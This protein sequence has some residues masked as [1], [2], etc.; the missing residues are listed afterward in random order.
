M[1]SFTK[2]I[3]TLSLSLG[4][5]SCFKPSTKSS[6]DSEALASFNIRQS[7][8][9]SEH[10][11]VDKNW[12]IPLSKKYNFTVCLQ[13]KKTQE[14]IIGHEFKVDIL[15][16]NSV[17]TSNAQN[18]NAQISSSDFGKTIKTDARGCLVWNESIKY[19]Y[20]ALETFI[21]QQRKITAAGL[22]KGSREFKFAINPWNK[23]DEFVDL[24]LDPNKIADRDLVKTDNAELSLKGQSK[25][26]PITVWADDLKF[27]MMD[28][29]TSSQRREIRVYG[30]FTPKI[31]IPKSDQTIS[32]KNIEDGI[33]KLK[34]FF[35][36]EVPSTKNKYI[37]FEIET[38]DLK[39][40]GGKVRFDSK[41]LLSKMQPSQ[42]ELKIAMI[43][44][45]VDPPQALNEF[46]GVYT[47][48]S[49]LD[50]N[51]RQDPQPVAE[52]NSNSYPSFKV[53]H[54]LQQQTYTFTAE[55]KIQAYKL[56]TIASNTESTKESSKDNS[57]DD[58]TN[59]LIL[60]GLTSASSY[61]L[62]HDNFTVK[63]GKIFTEFNKQYFSR[64]ITF[65]ACFLNATGSPLIG[66][67]FKVITF[68]NQTLTRTTDSSN[69]GCVKWNEEFDHLSYYAYEEPLVGKV[70]FINQM[71]EQ[72]DIPVALDPW[73]SGDG[74]DIHYDLRS[75]SQVSR[76]NKAK[77]NI[78][79]IPIKR[80][81]SSFHLVNSNK[82]TY[83]IDPYLNL[84]TTQIFK[85]SIDGASIIRND[86]PNGLVNESIQDGYY[87][88]R[89][90]LQKDYYDSDGSKK[91][92]VTTA[93][94]IIEFKNH[95]VVPGTEVQL[96]F[97]DWRF[98][99]VV[100][101][102]VLE[103][104][105]IN[106][107]KL[108]AVSGEDLASQVQNL[109]IRFAHERS[110]TPE[111]I[112]LFD[113][114]IDKASPFYSDEN[115]V[116][117]LV[118]LMPSDNDP[119]L[120][121]NNAARMMQNCEIGECQIGFTSGVSYRDPSIDP[122]VA[123]Y[124]VGDSHLINTTV[125]ML[126]I[127]EREL[128]VNFQKKKSI[129]FDFADFV[130]STFSDLIFLKPLNS[131]SASNTEKIQKN[132]DVVK[133]PSSQTPNAQAFLN[134]L[135]SYKVRSTCNTDNI[136][137]QLRN[138]FSEKA[139]EFMARINI[140]RGS[141]LVQD[142]DPKLSNFVAK[143]SMNDLVGIL[144]F[145]TS[146]N[147]PAQAASQ[148][149]FQ[150][151]YQ[152]IHKQEL[153]KRDLAFRLC[154]FWF[155]DYI[156]RQKYAQSKQVY[157]NSYKMTRSSSLAE[158][159][160]DKLPDVATQ[161][162]LIQD[163]VQYCIN[164][165]AS[166]GADSVFL[167][168]KKMKV[169]RFIQESKVD[170]QRLGDHSFS[171]SINAS[172]GMNLDHSITQNT[173]SSRGFSPMGFIGLFPQLKIISL[174][175]P[176]SFQLN[177]SESENA[178]H[179]NNNQ[180]STSTSITFNADQI[181]QGL[182]LLEYNP[183][184]N[185]RLNSDYVFKY[186]LIHQDANGDFTQGYLGPKLSA[187]EVEQFKVANGLRASDRKL[188]ADFQNKVDDKLKLVSRGLLIC[189][190]E[191]QKTPIHYVEKY[192]FLTKQLNSGMLHTHDFRNNLAIS[193]RGTNELSLFYNSVSP[194]VQDKFTLQKNLWN[195][196]EK[197][198]QDIKY[199]Q[200]SYPGVITLE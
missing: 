166:H 153:S 147:A 198:V 145:A 4:L 169:D 11:D 97:S 32:H 10:K 187:E 110:K 51:G 9:T 156:P 42:G 105:P 56:P 69:Y 185:I 63:G 89:I 139:A 81:I 21:T 65:S 25:S 161:E 129:N 125:S 36:S 64:E 173:A 77:E 113:E 17:Q 68:K 162:S 182:T 181:D 100:N 44:T 6:D 144:T 18:Q 135:N 127:R 101:N 123:K 141:W 80:S 83:D 50:L 61:Y 98:L 29:G 57:K 23:S 34:I 15:N 95:E 189:L 167:F 174:F 177:A 55:G 165:V 170:G 8:A 196:V 103:L 79:R 49:S 154:H 124:S 195:G 13:D 102:V 45:P 92:H 114:L 37:L 190:G 3:L 85:F 76:Y 108:H 143:I 155:R 149:S 130:S 90:A 20:W 164:E 112:S 163:Y 126:M 30:E 118:P 183:C 152:N 87:L 157:R 71:G 12:R 53:Y 175:T 180:N 22:H 93:Q 107:D 38:K 134:Q 194:N 60:D 193:F 119:S 41:A 58:L 24:K 35:V 117:Q 188:P 168:E 7:S 128:L 67:T 146:E 2:I 122:N 43:I 115:F 132:N 94:K 72:L 16:S 78:K 133:I 192:L 179:N 73:V 197:R 14:N 40:E 88:M 184:L 160:F 200:P 137:C 75:P 82:S 84:D 148:F 47:I 106:F 66:S 48:T 59:D 186:K 116:G 121:S 52:M 31:S 1:Q 172:E 74:S 150:N 70:S 131:L 151:L 33:F 39:M 136:T 158:E 111:S 171:V 27:R 120:Q 104:Y 28:I 86:R 109:N 62:T 91:E 96:F 199:K 19:N 178:G 140:G 54:Y 46:H 26:N 99:R 142:F 159:K 176:F 138:Y 5:S 191:I